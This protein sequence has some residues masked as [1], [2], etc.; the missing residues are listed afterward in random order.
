MTKEYALYRHGELMCTGTM[1]EIADHEGVKYNTVK[2]W[3]T[4]TCKNR[5]N[6]TIELVEIEED[7][8][9]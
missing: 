5:P 4:P 6:G 1:R 2:R 8:D 3:K 7:D 9:E